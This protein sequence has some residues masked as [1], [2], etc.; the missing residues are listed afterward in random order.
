[1]RLI[2]CAFLLLAVG[3]AAPRS[4]AADAAH[5]FGFVRFDAFTLAASNGVLFLTSPW[6]T[7][8]TPWDEAVVSWNAGCPDEAQLTVEARAAGSQGSTPFYALGVWSTNSDPPLRRSVKGQKDEWA[9]VKTDT[10]ICRLPAERVQV[11]LRLENRARPLQPGVLSQDAAE[12]LEQA[13]A[14]WGLKF[15]GVSTLNTRAPREPV[16]PNRNAWGRSLEVPLRSQLAH[17]DGK[18]WCSPASLA[19]V[20]ACWAK[21]LERPG[22]DLPLAEVAR[23]VFDPAWDGTGNWVFNTAFAGAF[24]GLR[25]YVTRLADLGEIE[26]WIA[27]GAPVIASVSFDLLNGKARDAGT[28]HLVVVTGFSES[29]EVWV[30]DPWPDKGTG[31]LVRKTVDRETFRRAWARSHQTVY[32]VYPTGHRPPAD[33][34]RHWQP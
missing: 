32:L 30:N 14:R 17:P 8:P 19:M 1:M 20:L 11:R 10:L 24:D 13:V 18:N 23:G 6:L 34:L 25:A 9:E 21:Q 28:G 33:R 22:L 2:C 4:A 16:S 15:L 5:F 26:D 12:A 7:P 27:S 3:P 31:P 29:G